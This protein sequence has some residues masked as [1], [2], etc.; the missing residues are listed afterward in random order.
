MPELVIDVVKTINRKVNQELL[1]PNTL[2]TCQNLRYDEILGIL[3]KRPSRRKYNSTTLGTDPIFSQIRYYKNSDN[4]KKY[5]IAT[6][7]FLKAGNDTAG[8]FANIKTG[9]TLNKRFMFITF[10]D[11][12]YCFNG[13][14]N[15]QVYDGTNNCV[16]MGVPVPTA[17]TLALGV[18]GV[19][20]GAYYYKVT[21]MIDSYQEGSAS[22][23]SAIINPS[24]QKVTVTIPVSTNTRVT[25]RKIY[26]T[27]AGGSVY[28]LLATVSNNTATTYDDNTEDSGLSVTQAPTDYGAPVSYRY[29]ILHKSRVFLARNSTHKSRIIFSD[30][31]SGIAY[32]DVFPADNYLDIAKDDGDEVTGICEDHVGNLVVWKNNSV[33]I[34]FT[35][36]DSSKGWSIGRPLTNFGNVTPYFLI[37]APIGIIYMTRFGANKNR[38]M[39]WSGAGVKHILEELDP[40]LDDIDPAQLNNTV[41]HFHNGKIHISYTDISEIPTASIDS[42]TKLLI[43]AAEADGTAGTSI[44]DS[45]T[46]PKT[47]TANGN[48]QI[49]TAQKVFGTGSVLFDGTG[50]YL[51]L[52]DS[53]DWNLG[54]GD[55]TVELRFRKPTGSEGNFVTQWGDAGNRSWGFVWDAAYI[56]F[57]YTTDGTTI[58]S[59]TISLGTINNDTWYHMAFVRSG[60]TLTYYL[61]GTSQGTVDLTGITIYDSISPLWIGAGYGV[62]ATLNG[63]ID[64]L[65]ISKGIARWTANFTPPTVAYGYGYNNK[66]LIIDA[67]TLSMVN[68]DN[69]AIDS[70][71]SWN[72]GTDLGELYTGTSNTDGFCYE[73]ETDTSASES[74][75]EINAKWGKL[76]FNSPRNRKRIKQVKIEFDRTV[77]SGTLSYYYSLDGASE[78]QIDIALATYATQGYYIYKFPYTAYCFHIQPRLYSNSDISS[79]GIKRQTYQYD[80]EPILENL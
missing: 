28:Y 10:K 48:A 68:I 33:R 39:L 61:N 56:Y 64:E 22:S 53:D 71:S 62:F 6:S 35:D 73:E 50:D 20:I 32:P 80:V 38:L 69:K 31:R 40:M 14:D 9:L 3:Y 11:L 59:K 49:D 46:T 72:S 70:F 43:H 5:V 19:L 12:L 15:N 76:N 4:T 1:P 63:W 78:T 23:A 24:N 8:T 36:S 29:G 2:Y 37:K 47:I 34:I 51:S 74:T 58:A 75:I 41:G 18:A 25:H 26:R 7:T 42:Y 21:Y 30:I 17:P 54:S 44:L 67:E 79:L 27:K 55:F 16:D 65:R 66:V 13:E 45:E 60:N 57:I 77:A 52:A